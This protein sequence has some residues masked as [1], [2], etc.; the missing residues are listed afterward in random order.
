MLEDWVS[1]RSGDALDRALKSKLKNQEVR[2]KGIPKFTCDFV[3][4]Y[5]VGYT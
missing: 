2:C 3:L 4:E 1:V 5:T